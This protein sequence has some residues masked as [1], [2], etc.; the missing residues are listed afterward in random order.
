MNIVEPIRSVEQIRKIKGN[1]LRQKN[2]RDLLLFTMGINSGL[3]I[4]D[5]LPLKLSDVIDEE[6]TIRDF[7][8]IV[9]KKTSK[10]RKI[11]FNQTIKD[12]LKIYLE[13]SRLYDLD[14]H[15]FRSE[16][17]SNNKPLTKTMCWILVQKWCREVGIKERV[18]THTLR[19]TFGYQMR[20]QGVPIERISKMLGH[21]NT[22]VTF[23]YLGISDDEMEKDIN[24]FNL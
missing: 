22:K 14:S 23:R 12:T 17:S 18:G 2:P 16:R 5:L 24:N 7:I 9:E 6:G 8:Y 1:L 21:S 13:K 19:K 15:L 3:R 11:I 4:S 20:V 10:Q